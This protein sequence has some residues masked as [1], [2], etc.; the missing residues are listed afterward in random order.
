MPHMFQSFDQTAA[1][2]LGPARV[3]ALR[4]LMARLGVDAVLVP[5]ADAHQGEYVPANAERLRWL[6]GF[7]GSAGYAVV[8]KKAAAVFTDGRY[9]L[10]AAA[11]VDSVTREWVHWLKQKLPSGGVIGYDPWLHTGGSMEA[12]RKDGAAK[13]F[14][15][16]ALPKNPVDSVWGS[17]RPRDPMGQVAVQPVA[18]TGVTAAAKIAAVQVDLKA[19]G[20]DAV[21]LTMPD[22]ICWLLN[23]RG[24]DIPHNPTVLAF[25]VV[26]AK[27]KPDLFIDTAKIAGDAKTHLAG[28]ATLRPPKSLSTSLA[29]LKADGKRVRLDPAS[30]ADW[31]FRKLGRAAAAASDPCILPKARKTAAELAGARAAHLRDGAAIVRY[32]AWLDREA[33]FGSIDEI[34]AVQKLEELR[35]ATQKLKEIAFDTISGS[36]PNGAIVHYRVTTATNRQLRAGELFLVDSGG[37]YQ[38]G[39]TDITRTVAIGKPSPEMCQRFTLVLKGHIAL[40]TARVPVGTRG[41]QLD[42]LARQALWPAGL[43]YDHGTGHGVGSYLNVHEGPQSISKRGMAALEPG[44]I[45]SNEPGYYKAGAYGIRIE[46]LEVVTEASKIGDGDRD[47]LGFEALTLAPMDRRLVVTSL[48]TE[49]E[50][51]WLNSY[52]A[53]VMTTLGPELGPDDRAWL[54]AATAPL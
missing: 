50:R 28:L 23:I 21:V 45:V 51:H 37:Q 5:R 19:D 38:D 17:E 29:A 15:L 33:V 54:A 24:A 39:T 27:G 47:M 13:G 43:D 6:T 26:P 2:D 35:A 44:M 53:R 42:T 1:P 8:T 25:M 18:L 32:L 14:K 40:A 49:M 20:H 22:S 36:G 3:K 30:A 11:Q 52:H 41:V 12:A 9:T 10:Q 46:N 16:K 48:L 7:S 31:L 4:T 34:T